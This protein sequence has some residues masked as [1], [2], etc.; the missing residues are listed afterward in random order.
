MTEYLPE[1]EGIKKGDTVLVDGQPCRFVHAVVS[2]G[3]VKHLMVVSEFRT[4]Y[5]VAPEEVQ[6]KKRGKK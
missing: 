2:E 5:A 1:Y 6:L 4:W 3:A